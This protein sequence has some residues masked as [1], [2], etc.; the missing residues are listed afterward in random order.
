MGERSDDKLLD[1]VRVMVTG[2]TGFVGG[3]TVRGLVRHGAKV[4]VAVRHQVSG[5]DPEAIRVVGDIGPDTCWDEALD[6]C[7]VVVHLAGVAHRFKGASVT[8]S[9]DMENVN[10]AGTIRLAKDA[11]RAGIR[12]LVFLSSIG[13]MGERSE[14]PLVESDLPNPQSEYAVGKLMAEQGLRDIATHSGLEVVVLRPTLVYGPGNPG[15]MSRLLKMLTLPIPLPF[16]AATNAKSLVSVDYLS[17]VICRSIAIEEAANET[18][19]VSDGLDISTSEIMK[20]L[21][22]GLG[23]RWPLVDV[24]DRVL[25]GVCRLIGRGAEI[26]RMLSTLQVDASKL[27]RVFGMKVNDEVIQQLVDV[28]RWFATERR[29]SIVG[30]GLFTE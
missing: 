1:N 13:V 18:F 16:G 14:R 24:S 28:G 3:Y 30:R 2:G 15:N 17:E 27:R 25:R 11:S 29:S 22:R 26:D 5:M 10:V 6:G 21:A 7:D 12:R 19:L 4:R 20:H 9:V 23:R 8:D